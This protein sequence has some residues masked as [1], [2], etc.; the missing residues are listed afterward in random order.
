MNIQIRKAQKADCAAI[1]EH[2][3]EFGNDEQANYRRCE[4]QENGDGLLLIAWFDDTPVGRL[5]IRWAGSH[6]IP[7][8]RDDNPVA[9]TISECPT[10]DQIEVAEGLRGKGIGTLL[11]KHAEMQVKAYGYE[12]SSI[13]AIHDDRPRRLYERLGYAD[14]GIG[15]FHTFGTYIN[16]KGE[17]VPWDNGHQVFLMKEL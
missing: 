15:V 1:A 7:R 5:W 17:E 12:R 11:I 8:I 2:L 16:E 6:E 14:P 3:Q 13:T 4:A 10:F 9:A